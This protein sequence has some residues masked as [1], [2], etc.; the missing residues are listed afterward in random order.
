ML[1]PVAML[2]LALISLLQPIHIL[3]SPTPAIVED[4]IVQGVFR[5]VLIIPNDEENVAIPDESDT[6]ARRD[7]IDTEEKESLESRLERYSKML[8]PADVRQ[9]T[10]TN[11]QILADISEFLLDDSNTEKP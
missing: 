7:D 8:T 10:P 1:A 6:S 9:D 4:R 2:S 11:K 5:K 3:A